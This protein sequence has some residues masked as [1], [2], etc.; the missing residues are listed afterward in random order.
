MDDG[1]SSCGFL[2]KMVEIYVDSKQFHILPGGPN[3]CFFDLGD[4]K[5]NPA[6]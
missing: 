6:M 4:G 2:Q 3:I 5:M 1:F